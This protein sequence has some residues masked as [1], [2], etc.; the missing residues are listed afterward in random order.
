[1]LVLSLSRA[2]LLAWNGFYHPPI[3]GVRHPMSPPPNTRV[4]VSNIVRNKPATFYEINVVGTPIN[5]IVAIE[6]CDKI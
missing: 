1:M 3:L 4:R 2:L 6:S 5:H